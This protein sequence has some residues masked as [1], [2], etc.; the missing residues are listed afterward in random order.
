MRPED[1][2]AAAERLARWVARYRAELRDR[3]V[4]PATKPGEVRAGMPAHAPEHPESIEAIEADLDRL[5]V[6]H[7]LHWQ[8]P[9]FFG[10]FPA[11]SDL[12][13]VLGD[14][15]SGGL[16]VQGMLWSASPACTE[17]ETH[18][19]DWCVD[20]LD[21]PDA[22]RSTGAGGGVIQDTASSAA[23]CALVA[24]RERVTQGRSNASGLRS[25]ACP[26]LACYAS[27]QAHSSIEKAV[28]I[29]GLG[30]LSMRRIPTDETMAMQAHALARAMR[31]DQEDGIRP[32]FVVATVGT[33]SSLAMDDLLST[34]K[35][36]KQF[37]A[38]LHVDAA[39]AGCAAICPEHRGIHAGLE[40]AD[41]YCTNPH[42]WLGVNF[43]CDLFYV[44][45]RAALVGALGIDPEFLKNAATASGEVI[46]YRDWQVPLGRRFR[47]LK[48]W[49]LL[50]LTG[51]EALRERVR[52]SCAMSAAW[53]ERA[54][55][56]PD[57]EVLEP[58]RLGLV[59][60]RH[61]GGDEET[62]GLLRRVNAS[63]IA[64]LT[65]T[66]IPW[67]QTGS[68]DPRFTLRVAIGNP[69]TTAEDLDRLWELLVAAA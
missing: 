38:W 39:L 26:P 16:G 56:H 57:L 27:T 14:L 62:E 32:C 13:S 5:V 69:E 15:V 41:S 9:R 23:L 22:F 43:D 48:L 6:P 10:Y 11:L 36:C 60:L 40:G 7:L 37:G 20:L 67:A 45:D 35:L 33:T 52:R 29:A 49:F 42:K 1:F 30:S 19:M 68:P 64:F 59:C 28:R 17:I 4:A 54:R 58:Q 53:A 3:P 18:L 61:R 21:L 2:P 47:A 8:H 31:R 50:R 66:R 65:H 63:G 44:R 46:D 25:P 34:A 24:A 55:Q 51:A 12:S